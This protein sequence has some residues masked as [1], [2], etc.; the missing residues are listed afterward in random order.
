MENT[1]NESESSSKVTRK[2]DTFFN[3]KTT[4]EDDCIFMKDSSMND[5]IIMNTSL[6]EIITVNSNQENQQHQSTN[7]N[8]KKPIM[9]TQI[10]EKKVIDIISNADEQPQKSILANVNTN[11]EQ[12]GNTLTSVSTTKRNVAVKKT[13]SQ[14][15]T[16]QI[17]NPPK[18]SLNSSH[19]VIN[20]INNLNDVNF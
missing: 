6:N 19:R 16:K 17:A 7:D 11:N 2:V 8:N 12:T 9:V 13:T 14:I 15:F 5:D 18:R 20:R 3:K 1:K 4:D 10:L